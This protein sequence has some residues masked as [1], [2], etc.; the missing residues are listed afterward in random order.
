MVDNY[1]IV[2]L[3]S[4][5]TPNAHYI[6]RGYRDDGGEY[7]SLDAAKSSTLK[8]YSVNESIY[9]DDTIDTIKI[10]NKQMF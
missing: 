4:S 1:T 7:V 5:G 9:L 8:K 10:K 2:R 6:F 3:N